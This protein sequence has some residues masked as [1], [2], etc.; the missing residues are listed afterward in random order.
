[1]VLT[2]ESEFITPQ[3]TTTACNPCYITWRR[4]SNANNSS[5][6][7]ICYLVS[8]IKP[9]HSLMPFTVWHPLRTVHIGCINNM[10]TVL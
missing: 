3:T 1:M 5:S 6:T 9:D 2:L 4:L 10:Y 8:T 7:C